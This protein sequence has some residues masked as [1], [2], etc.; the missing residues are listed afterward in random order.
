MKMLKKTLLVITLAIALTGTSVLGIATPIT[1]YASTTV[2]SGKTTQ[3]TK[4]TENGYLYL[5]VT[6]SIV[7]TDGVSAIFI[8]NATQSSTDNNYYCDYF[9]WDHMGADAIF[10]HKSSGTGFLLMISPSS[11]SSFNKEVIYMP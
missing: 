1:T 4:R 6:Y 5:T 2:V 9:N 8:T 7:T 11:G 3:L 10:Y